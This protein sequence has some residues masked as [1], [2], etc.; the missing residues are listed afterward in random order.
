MIWKRFDKQAIDADEAYVAVVAEIMEGLPSDFTADT[1]GS[2]PASREAA[3]PRRRRKRTRN[4][5]AR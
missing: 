3:L 4:Q 1:R 2:G 5:G